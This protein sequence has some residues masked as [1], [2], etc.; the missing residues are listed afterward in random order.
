[1]RK[2]LLM[3]VGLAMAALFVA[4]PV[5]TASAGRVQLHFGVGPYLYPYYQPYPYYD[6]Y[7][8][9]RRRY[10]YEEECVVRS[11]P[12]RKCRRVRKCWKTK[13][14]KRKC[15]TVRR[16]RTKWVRRTVCY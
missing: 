5:Q 14:G 1:M 16:C 11:W 4:A 9:P 12:V 6:P 3:G 13:Y 15:K 10:L 8:E 7:Y 2:T